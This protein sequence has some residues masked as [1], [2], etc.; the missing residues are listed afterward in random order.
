MS[1]QDF[2]KFGVFDA[3]SMLEKI[4]RQEEDELYRQ[5]YDERSAIVRQVEEAL[6]H[7]RE[8]SVRDLIAF[9]EKNH[10]PAVEKQTALIKVS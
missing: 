7:E 8:K 10:V 2:E 1:F 5:I 6:R 9:F 4:H 3:Q